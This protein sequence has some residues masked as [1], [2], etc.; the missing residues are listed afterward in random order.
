MA[1]GGVELLGV[2]ARGELTSDLHSGLPS[3]G[4]K[5]CKPFAAPDLD[6]IV[7]HGADR[8]ACRHRVWQLALAQAEGKGC[9]AGP[10]EIHRAV[11]G[12]GVDIHV[13]AFDA[14][15]QGVVPEVGLVLRGSG[16]AH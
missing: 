1:P 11:L 5:C 13:L 15:D 10:G 9:I 16:F 2:K 7:V 3:F 12:D 8:P 6:R 4:N 14:T